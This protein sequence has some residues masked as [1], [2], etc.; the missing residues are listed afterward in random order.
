MP[1]SSTGV[2]DS[3]EAE[4]GTTGFFEN[5]RSQGASELLRTHRST[6]SAFV[7]LSTPTLQVKSCLLACF[8]RVSFSHSSHQPI[9]SK[10]FVRNQFKVVLQPQQGR[11]IS[12]ILIFAQL[13]PSGVSNWKSQPLQQFFN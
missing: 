2:G 12:L 1:Y 11:I 3:G 10:G 8:P 5:R 4:H 9:L 7:G 13:S 6:R